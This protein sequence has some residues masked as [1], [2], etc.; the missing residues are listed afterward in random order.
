MILL[1]AAGL[2]GGMNHN[3]MGQEGYG[4]ENSS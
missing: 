3:G 4:R 2:Y 1:L